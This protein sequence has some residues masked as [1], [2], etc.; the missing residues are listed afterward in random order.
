MIQNLGI[1]VFGI[2][3]ILPWGCGDKPRA[4]Q[5][6][7]QL[8]I[9]LKIVQLEEGFLDIV[10][11]PKHG[12]GAAINPCV[13]CRIYNL[14]KAKAYMEE[15]GAGFIFEADFIPHGPAQRLSEFFGDSFRNGHCGNSSGLGASDFSI[16]SA[17]CG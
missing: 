7:D 12:Y 16:D 9:P 17:A 4:L 3:F 2:H 6:A 10:K 1:K 11:D 5:I 15:I 14:K 13:D 8:G